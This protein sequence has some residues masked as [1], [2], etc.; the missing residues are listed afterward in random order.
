[1]VNSVVLKRN[2]TAWMASLWSSLR[3]WSRGYKTKD[4][5][6][7]GVTCG[8]LIVVVVWSDGD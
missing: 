3:W 7:T 4:V 2:P 5:V 6:G 1:M 8:V